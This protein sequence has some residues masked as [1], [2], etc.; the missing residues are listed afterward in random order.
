MDIDTR[1]RW[2]RIPG[3]SIANGVPV[4]SPWPDATIVY[5]F[6]DAQAKTDLDGALYPGMR[7][8]WGAGLPERFKIREGSDAECQDPNGADVLTVISADILSTSVG[9][10]AKDAAHPRG[11]TMTLTTRSDIGMLD[12]DANIAHEWGHAW[13]LYH[14]RG[15]R[16]S[17]KSAQELTGASV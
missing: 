10:V 12:T 16:L 4:G 3:S 8:W 17:S 1:G 11:P 2:F 7:V 13:G 14:V 9:K 15:E 5:C 6:A